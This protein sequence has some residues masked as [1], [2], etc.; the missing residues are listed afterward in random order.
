MRAL[1][2]SELLN[3][4]EEGLDRL[5]AQRALDL[6]AAAC[7]E[8]PTETLGRLSIGQRDARLRDVGAPAAGAKCEGVR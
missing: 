1:L 4:W 5:P 7:P 3:V 6:L 8:T 2:A